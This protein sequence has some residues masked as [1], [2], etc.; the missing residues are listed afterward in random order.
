MRGVAEI[1]ASP[2]VHHWAKFE[3][4]SLPFCKRINETKH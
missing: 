2:V 3:E 4:S 1:N